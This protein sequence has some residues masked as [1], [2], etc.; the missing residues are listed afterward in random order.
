MS[1]TYDI[2]MQ[3]ANLDQLLIDMRSK[4][5]ERINASSA[6]LTDE[7]EEAAARHKAELEAVSYRHRLELE[8]IRDEYNWFHNVLAEQEADINAA[9]GGERAEAVEYRQAAE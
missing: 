2:G 5:Q 8:A 4:T 6:R 9:R 1:T 7:L 3:A